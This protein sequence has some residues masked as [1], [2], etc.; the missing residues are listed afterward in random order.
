MRYFYICLFSVLLFSAGCATDY[1]LA[2]IREAR[3][4][5][6]KEHP[7]L[8]EESMH[9]IKF[10]TPKLQDTLLYSRGSSGTS[11]HDIMQTCVTWDLPD[12][13]G[14][15]LMVVG[16]GQRELH[17][18]SP[19]RIIFKRFNFVNDLGKKKKKSRKRQRTSR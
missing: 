13:D 4:Y 14:K 3:E 19:N 12:C 5:A 18:W 17:N 8:S 15:S 7:D 2:I 9:W 6:L 1:R 11:K 10:T 16:F